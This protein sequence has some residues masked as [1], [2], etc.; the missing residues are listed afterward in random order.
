M[1]F[2]Q[3]TLLALAVGLAQA[4]ISFNS[5]LESDDDEMYWNAIIRP[6][7]PLTSAC[8]AAWAAPIPCSDWL[9][10]FQGS[11]SLSEADVFNLPVLSELCAPECIAGLE[12]WRDDL[13]DACTD[14]DV[15]AAN[16]VDLTRSTDAATKWEGSERGQF[17]LSSFLNESMYMVEYLYYAGCLKDLP[18]D[19]FCYLLPSTDPFIAGPSE[20]IT[21]TT[22]PTS[23]A[24]KA[25][26]NSSCTT[27]Q[28]LWM[29]DI[30]GP[31]VAEADFS[32]QANATTL[33]PGL[34]TSKY[35]FLAE[36]DGG[37]STS[38]SGGSGSSSGS[39]SGSGSGSA[40]GNSTEEG[41]AVMLRGGSAL[42][43]GVA[44]VVGAVAAGFSGL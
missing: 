3:T 33:C 13:R 42:V 32:D 9:L 29:L 35:P 21:N 37:N 20:D 27:Q 14:E 24:A 23:D 2:S 39:G 40:S 1:R 28:N 12:S 19:T 5:S 17:F 31:T 22:D 44:A 41:A 15:A 6:S 25:Y 4:T 26:C 43:W 34:D 18:T 38:G 30:V 16:T 7:A 10:K 36:I 11:S 8:T